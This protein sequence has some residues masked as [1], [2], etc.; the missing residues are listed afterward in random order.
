VEINYLQVRR[1]AQ[2]LTKPAVKQFIDETVTLSKRWPRAGNPAWTDST[3][4]LNRA[5]RGTVF[6]GPG[7]EPTGR[8][9]NDKSYALVVHNGGRARVI[10]ARN[11]KYMKFRWK[12]K[13][14]ALTFLR[15]VRH[16]K[17]KGSFFITQPAAIIARRHGYRVQTNIVP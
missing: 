6:D 14:G 16:P 1:T 9:E 8:I 12:R 3:G 11:G 4:A 10:Y 5:T 7:G 15:T 13:A 2:K 17:T